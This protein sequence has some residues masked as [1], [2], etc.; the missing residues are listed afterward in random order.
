LIT[1]A[2]S[3]IPI[4]ITSG[5]QTLSVNGG[6]VAFSWNKEQSDAASNSKD[7]T[8]IKHRSVTDVVPQQTS[9]NACDQFQKSDDC[10]VPA[11]GTGAQEFWHEVRSKCPAD[12][13][14][15]SLKQSVEDEQDGN[16][17]HASGKSK[18]K[19]RDEKDRE[20][21]QQDVSSTP[22]IPIDRR[23]N[24]PDMKSGRPPN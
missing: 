14:K 1:S 17:Y 12:R 22:S 11:D 10:A 24:P 4:V 6:P 20:R 5:A 15:Y 23:E 8:V 16:R 9:Y 18:A 13:P 21:R 7:R 2:R 19:I 3:R